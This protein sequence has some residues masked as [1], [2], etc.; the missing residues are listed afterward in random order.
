M[1]FTSGRFV[2]S[3]KA[4]NNN[5]KEV[6]L[7]TSLISNIQTTNVPMLVQVSETTLSND[8]VERLKYGKE[9]GSVSHEYF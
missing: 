3:I 9:K 7:F 5:E 2:K 8:V 4:Y 1:Y 6:D